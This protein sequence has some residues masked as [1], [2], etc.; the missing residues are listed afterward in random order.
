MRIGHRGCE[1]EHS[2]RGGETSAQRRRLENLIAT[3]KN[4]RGAIEWAK[5]NGPL[6]R[7]RTAEG[8]KRMT[9]ENL[10]DGTPMR[11]KNSDG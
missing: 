9:K 8:K 2:T 5:K 1:K 7:E 4:Q 11:R 3:F 10:P 6:Q